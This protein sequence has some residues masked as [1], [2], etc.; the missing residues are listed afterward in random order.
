MNADR[1]DPAANADRADR[2]PQEIAL[3]FDIDGTLTPPR[4]EL[5][6]EMAAALGRLRVP[7]HVAAG[8]DLAL[9]E[10]QFLDPLWRL[11][12]RGGFEAFVS[13]GAAHYRCDYGSELSI[14]ERSAFDLRTHLG[15]DAFARLL[16]GVESVLESE[17]HALPPSLSVIGA[18]IVDRRG[19]LNVTPIGRPP[20]ALDAAARA[21][22]DAF[23]DFDRSTGYRRR[24]LQSLRR[25]LDWLARDHRLQVLLG[26][27]TS[28]DLVVEGMDKTAAVRG[29]LAL[30]F[31][32]VVFVG[33]ALWEGGND[34]VVSDLVARWRQEGGAC[35][36]E[37]VQVDGWRHT[38]EVLRAR[39][40]L[41]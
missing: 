35:P 6:G 38:I 17:E 19:M 39:G 12:F 3:L 13:N 8:S 40:W 25:E 23:A 27:E 9:V 37:A 11:G 31:A 1:T 21:N 4:H 5:E 34:A 24:M 28:F 32:R 15:D 14:V 36:L 2:H 7:F 20:G 29:V 18:R 30:G 26:G 33:D 16:A 41:T 10:P 22:R